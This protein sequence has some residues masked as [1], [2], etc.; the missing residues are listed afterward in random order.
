MVCCALLGTGAV[1]VAT[2]AAVVTGVVSVEV[3]WLSV[4][5]GLDFVTSMGVTAP[6]LRKCLFDKS[7]QSA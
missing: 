4:F 7:V 2:E 6:V 5:E 3:L 1:L